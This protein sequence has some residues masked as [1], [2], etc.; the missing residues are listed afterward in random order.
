MVYGL[1]RRSGD[2]VV[3]VV[4]RVV[5]VWG[6]CVL[7]CAPSPR[8]GAVQTLPPPLVRHLL[9][10][11]WDVGAIVA[12]RRVQRRQRSAIDDERGLLFLEI[13]LVFRPRSLIGHVDWN[14]GSGVWQLSTG[15]NTERVWRG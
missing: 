8:E 13:C 12:N 10:P 1:E 15:D 7:P 2:L 5:V 4:V 11:D 14:V 3:R 9:L 6:G